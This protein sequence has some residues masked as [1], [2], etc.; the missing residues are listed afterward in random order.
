MENW[1]QGMD[2][3]SYCMEMLAAWRF[4]F[5]IFLKK[6][7]GF[8]IRMVIS[9]GI[10][11]LGSLLIYPYFT[12]ITNVYNWVWFIF[13]FGLIIVLCYFCCDIMWNDAIMAAS[14]GA[15]L[16]HTAS[17]LFIVVFYRGIIPE[18]SGVRYWGMY[19]CVYLAGVVL[20]ARRRLMEDII[21]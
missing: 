21:M 6:R 12:D 19:L 14:C 16:Q 13:I 10:L 8:W 17:S 4:D 2:G 1:L 3:F 9:I 20:I 15:L 5:F 18:F 7:N 11:F